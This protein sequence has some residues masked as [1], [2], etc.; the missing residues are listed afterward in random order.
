MEPEEWEVVPAVL[1]E[2]TNWLNDESNHDTCREWALFKPLTSK[3]LPE[4]SFPFLAEVE[5]HYY[6]LLIKRSRFNF[7]D[8]YWVDIAWRDDTGEPLVFVSHQ[9]SL[10]DYYAERQRLEFVNKFH[11]ES[12][13]KMPELPNRPPKIPLDTAKQ[14]IKEFQHSKWNPKKLGDPS[15]T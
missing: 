5:S 7:A 1:E 9:G 10:A 14:I 15:G 6:R 2:I 8:K 11:K 3:V 13:D 4:G 12:K